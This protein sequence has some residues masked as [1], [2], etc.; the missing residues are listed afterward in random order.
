ME[1]IQHHAALQR[2][3]A[4]GD[5]VFLEERVAGGDLHRLLTD[6]EAALD[7]LGELSGKSVREDLVATIFSRFCVGK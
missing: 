4:V 2:D 1:E 7:A 6:G 3:A 5:T